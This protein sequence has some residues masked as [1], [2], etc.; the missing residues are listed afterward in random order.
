MLGRLFRVLGNDRMGQCMMM[1]IPV[2]ARRCDQR[3][4]HALSYLAIFECKAAAIQTSMPL[5]HSEWR[6]RACTTI[7]NTTPIKAKL[8]GQESGS[9]IMGW[10]WIRLFACSGWPGAP[11]SAPIAHAGR[12]QCRSLE[13]GHRDGDPDKPLPDHGASIASW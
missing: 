11:P 9:S 7:T 8:S 13:Y 3:L 4:G 6:E 12:A 1:W 2:M 10:M 5:G